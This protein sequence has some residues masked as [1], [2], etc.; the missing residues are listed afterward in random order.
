MKK[1]SLLIEIY[2]G[3]SNTDNYIKL[4]KI[5]NINYKRVQSK[6]VKGDLANFRLSNVVLLPPQLKEIKYRILYQ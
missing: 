3:T 4:C 1:G 5:A 2:P 6:I